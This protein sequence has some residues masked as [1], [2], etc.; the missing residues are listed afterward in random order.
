M[1]QLLLPGSAHPHPPLA[2]EDLADRLGVATAEVLAWTQRGLAM[3]DGLIDPFAA[4]NWLCW[5]NLERCPLLQRRWQTYVRWFTPHV[6]AQ[7]TPQRYRV[8]QA[9]RL[10]LPREVDELQWYLP[11]IPVCNGQSEVRAESAPR[12]EGAQTSPAGAFTRLAWSAPV[13]QPEVAAEWAVTVHPHPVDLFPGRREL[14]ELVTALVGEFHYEYRHHRPGE[15]PEQDL[16]AGVDGIS[17]SCLDCALELG[18]RLDELGRPWRLCAGVVASTAV[19]NPHFWLKVDAGS[20]WTPVDPSL[21]AIARMLG[22]DW[23]AFV[24]AY[25]GGCDARRITLAETDLHVPL[26]PGGPSLGSRLGEA[27]ALVGGERLNAWAC[28][29]WVCGEC[30]WS[31]H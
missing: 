19:A 3:R 2:A 16:V 11:R 8:R 21:P 1:S 12:A 29:D 9:H 25:V 17:G 7:D 26:V 6:H 31:F 22:L 23:R 13:R 15:D 18:R 14:V 27:I 10:Y 20:G 28:L 24:D 30:A 5:G 4:A